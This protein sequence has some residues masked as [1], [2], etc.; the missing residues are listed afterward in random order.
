MAFG[1]H[2]PANSPS[3]AVRA[4]FAFTKIQHAVAGATIAQLVVQARHTDIVALGSNPSRCRQP[5]RHQEQR[6]AT[7]TRGQ[8]AF[9]GG[10]LGEYQVDDVVGEV[11]V[12]AGNPHLVAMQ[13]VGT[14][15]LRQRAG[16]D[17]GQR[18]TGLRF[19]QA[20]GA[21]HTARQ[22]VRHVAFH[23]HRVRVG[24]QQVGI[25]D[26]EHGVAGGGHIG[27][28]QPSHAGALNHERQ[29]HAAALRVLRSGHETGR[30]EGA[31]GRADGRVY[32]HLAID[33]ARFVN[34]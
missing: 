12:A 17:I 16:S 32:P 7:G 27:G 30:A 21:E 4:M 11:V 33:Q 19:G 29:L 2:T 24:Q 20:H 22:H 28:E 26:G 18:R 15:R 1:A 14:V 6:Q 5:L 34:I 8:S 13:A 23:Q 10:H 3:Q 9:R 31:Q 25:R